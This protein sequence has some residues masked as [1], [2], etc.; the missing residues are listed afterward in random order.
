MRIERDSDP[1]G[2]DPTSLE[3]RLHAIDPPPVPEDLLDR[4]LVTVPDAETIAVDRPAPRARRGWTGWRGRLMVTAAG[5]LLMV[6]TALVARPR[7]ADAATLLQEVRQAEIRVAASHTVRIL[8]GPDETRREEVWY[9]RDRGRREEIRINDQ[10]TAT[11]VRTRRW[12]FR[13]D[14]RDH[15]VA[16]WSTELNAG[17]GGPNDSDGRV[18]GGEDMVRWAEKH[19]AEVRVEPDTL[20]GRKLRKIT[21]RWPG[22]E[23]GGTFPRDETIWFEPDTLRPVLHQIAYDEG[24]SLEIRSDYPDP[25]AVPDDLFIFRPPP[26]VTIEINDPDLGRQVYSEGRTGG[27]P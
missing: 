18:F 11:V 12:V 22:P 10:P 20:D 17:H 25:G 4:C 26:D 14:I 16:A 8:V 15:L 13:W 1:G 6:V 7:P 24:K 9:A 23:N 21:L 19:R 3:H 2:V 5:V 27:N